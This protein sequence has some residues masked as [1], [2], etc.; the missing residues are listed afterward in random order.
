MAEKGPTVA[1]FTAIE[2]EISALKEENRK[3]K[4]ELDKAGKDAVSTK[5]QGVQ[6]AQPDVNEKGNSSGIQRDGTR[7]RFNRG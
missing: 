2:A 3:F 1:Q 4:A 7:V 5:T 6:F